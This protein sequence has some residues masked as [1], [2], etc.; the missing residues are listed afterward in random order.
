M[1][2]SP[3]LGPPLLSESLS[4]PL[5]WGMPAVA[6]AAAL[7]FGAFVADAAWVV[8]GWAGVV[9]AWAGVVGACAGVELD[10]DDEPQPAITAAAS[11]AA[12][13]YRR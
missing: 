11:A 1:F 8:V 13:E 10:D 7:D 6:D 5:F 9:G 4:P 3:S 2:P 12:I